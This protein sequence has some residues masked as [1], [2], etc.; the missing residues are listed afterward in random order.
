MCKRYNLAGMG[1]H[2]GRPSPSDIL[3]WPAIP[4]SMA[5]LLQ[6]SSLVCRTVRHDAPKSPWHVTARRYARETQGD[7]LP[8]PMLVWPASAA[9]LLVRP[10][11]IILFYQS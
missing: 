1:R 5:S 10:A 7:T 2:Y 8:A 9:P 3:G 6:P 4:G 11:S